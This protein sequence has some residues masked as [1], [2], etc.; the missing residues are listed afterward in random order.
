MSR[1]GRGGVSAHARRAAAPL[2]GK[3]PFAGRLMRAA[4]PFSLLSLGPPFSGFLPLPPFRLLGASCP[5]FFLLCLLGLLVVGDFLETE[6]VLTGLFVKLALDPLD[7]ELDLGDL[8][9]LQSVHTTVRDF[10][11]LVD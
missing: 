6:E 4:S 9:E 3:G 2:A 7:N 8:N 5:F 1:R 11:G 10:Q